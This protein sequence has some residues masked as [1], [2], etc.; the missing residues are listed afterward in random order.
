ML[1]TN[2]NIN[3]DWGWTLAN[4]TVKI[5]SIDA[6]LSNYVNYLRQPWHNRSNDRMQAMSEM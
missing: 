3:D 4:A 5:F 2:D 1:Y 6:Q